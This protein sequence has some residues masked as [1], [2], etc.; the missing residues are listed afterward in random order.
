MNE[1]IKEIKE[2]KKKEKQ[3]DIYITMESKPK[4][5]RNK[6]KMNYVV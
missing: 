4:K 2:I 3:T 5:K 6:Y 1:I